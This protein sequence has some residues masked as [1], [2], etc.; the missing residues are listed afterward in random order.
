MEGPDR[1]DRRRELQYACDNQGVVTTLAS[2]LEQLE[3]KYEILDK[4]R[5]GG[6]GSVYKVRHR[7]LDEVRVVKVMRP[8]LAE[9]E[10][11]RE[12]FL[13]E[14]KVAIRLHHQNLAQIYDFTVDDKGYAYLVMEFIDG[15]N[16]QEVIKVL[17]RPTIGLVLEI[18][19]QSLDALGYLHRKRIIHRD[20]SPDNL[21]VTRDEDRALQVKLIDL[22][23]AKKRDEEDGLTS[24][25]TFL[26]KVRYSSPEQFRAQD[27]VEI[28]ARSDLYSFGVVLYEMLTGSYPIKGSS[29]A[30]LI[31]G[32]LSHPPLDFDLSDPNGEVPDE[33]RK[34]VLQTL[35][36]KPEER[37][38]S[39]K[40][41][42]EALAP[43]RAA[44]AVEE[45]QLRAIFDVPT[46]TTRRIQT[47]KPGSSQ[48]RM[49]RNFGLSTTPP[50]DSQSG[51]I[52][53]LESTVESGSHGQPDAGQVAIQSQIRALLLGASKLVEGKHY[54]EARLQLTTVLELAPDNQE[55][56][57]LLRAAEAADVKLQQRRQKA[58]AGVRKAIAAENFDRAAALLKTSIE[59]HGEA[60]IFDGVGAELGQ[61][62][63]RRAARLERIKEINTDVDKLVETEEFGT[64]ITLLREGLGL[65]PDNRQLQ[66]R[67]KSVQAGHDAQIVAL[68]R[69]KEIDD[70]VAAISGHIADGGAAE[71]ERAL[72]VATKLFGNEARFSEL[73]GKI[74]ALR[75]RIRLEEAE[76]LRARARQQIENTDFD[77]AIATLDE[78]HRLAPEAEETS[79]LLAAAREGVRLKKEAERRQEIVAAAALNIE[80]LILAGRLESAV[81]FIDTAQDEVGEFKEAGEL[82]S[83]VEKE[84]A[85]RDKKWSAVDKLIQQALEK[86]AKE[87]FA[88]AEEA[89]EKARSLDSEFPEASDLIAEAN[90][91]IRRR[92][93]SHRRQM[94]I[95]KVVESIEAQLE[96]GDVEEARRELGVARRLLGDSDT[97][98]DLAAIIEHGERALR[99]QQIADLVKKASEEERSFDETVADLETALNLDSHNEMAQRLLVEARMANRKSLEEQRMQDAADRLG[100]IDS[101]IAEGKTQQALSSLETV[102]AEFGD[103]R[104]ARSLRQS[105]EA[106]L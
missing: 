70:T 90:A 23:I 99:T 55:A 28:G 33:L 92:I 45:D 82:R 65:E 69:A 95:D 47:I 62:R 35:E 96:K 94:A 105:L 48:S 38:E 2:P 93:D 98:D 58:A 53:D 68:R 91:E 72:R 27:G 85:F 87:K 42:R 20:V 56:K 80:R 57:Q 8:H 46:E 13:R 43:L 97:V 102:T 100:A 52:A 88:E 101:L 49:N 6:M 10:V 76:E 61:A 104:E 78:A 84:I 44:C 54:D 40:K 41:L 34:I 64:A 71:A 29:V 60:E 51:E 1:I 4:I 37:F 36:K 77:A 86:S 22:G 106:Q 103:F 50:P 15:L 11:L 25:G 73:A 63:E 21:L 3:G 81:R 24:E 17:G 74:E 14:A 67:L 30:S 16:L 66:E 12:R 39:T 79:E 5:E 89:I 32:H 7:L 83:R 75:D 18:A 26:G 59:E 9:D 31:S 19:D